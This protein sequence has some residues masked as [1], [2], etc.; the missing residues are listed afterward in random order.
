MNQILYL[1]IADM[2]EYAQNVLFNSINI[3]GT[4]TFVEK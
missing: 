2:E 1:W 3:M 4:A